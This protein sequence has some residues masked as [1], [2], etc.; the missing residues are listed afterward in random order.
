[1]VS[2]GFARRIAADMLRESMQIDGV[3]PSSLS[4]IFE[5]EPVPLTQFITDPNY[6]ANPRLGDIQFEFVRHLEQIYKPDLYPAMVEEFGV[7]WMPVRMVN[8]LVAQW[9]KGSGKDHC[10]RLGVARTADLLMCL[11]SPQEY[12]GMP[13]QDDIHVLN[14]A[15]SADQ[16]RRAF[17]S[18]LKKLFVTNSHLQQYFRGD[19]K[20]GEMAISI[21]LQKNV[22]LVSGHSMAET[23][24]GL[25]LI[26]AIADEISAFKTAEELA[27]S[28]RVPEGRAPMNSAEGIIRVLYSSARTRFPESFKLAQI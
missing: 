21:R 16:A 26:V 4:G 13:S 7:H 9:G 22:E 25:N 11:R 15:A 23:Q 6:L 5:R 12:F 3:K 24:E 10:C 17:F 27:R 2:G 8:F 20:P 28:G 14:V 18:P 1:M 19:I